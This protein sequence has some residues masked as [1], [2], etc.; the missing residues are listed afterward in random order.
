MNL[1]WVVKVAGFKVHGSG[2]EGLKISKPFYYLMSYLTFDP[3]DR[4]QVF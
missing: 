3:L 2:L 1:L 4:Q